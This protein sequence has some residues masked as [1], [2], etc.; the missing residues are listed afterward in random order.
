MVRRALGAGP[1]GA[2]TVLKANSGTGT[3]SV[4]PVGA[5]KRPEVCV[6]HLPLAI[7]RFLRGSRV[8]GFEGVLSFET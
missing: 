4:W 1:Q 3:T 2:F 7:A 8:G 5:K 6:L